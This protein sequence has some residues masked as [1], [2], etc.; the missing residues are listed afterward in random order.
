MELPQIAGASSKFSTATA[1]APFAQTTQLMK[2]RSKAS[3]KALRTV[4]LGSEDV[5]L[6]P[7]RCVIYYCIIARLAHEASTLP[8]ASPLFLVNEPLLARLGCI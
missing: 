5:S 6:E 2:A 3:K 4:D 8:H 1:A 7:T